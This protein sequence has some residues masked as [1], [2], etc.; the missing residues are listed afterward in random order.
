MKN[1]QFKER[2]STVESTIEF[3][4]AVSIQR[5]AGPMANSCRLAADSGLLGAAPVRGPEGQYNRSWKSLKFFKT[6]AFV[7][8]GR[9]LR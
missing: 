3:S 8:K 7:R 6:K 5:P 4:I 2:L 1:G 9:G